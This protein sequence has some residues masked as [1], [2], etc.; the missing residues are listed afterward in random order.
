[1]YS[2]GKL[3]Y[4]ASFELV[5]VS[6]EFDVDLLSQLFQLIVMNLILKC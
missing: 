2:V 4:L 6:Y 5:V 1:M 3:A